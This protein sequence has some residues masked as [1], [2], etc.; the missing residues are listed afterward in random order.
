M[1][2]TTQAVCAVK[3]YILLRC[4]CLAPTLTCKYQATQKT[5]N[6]VESI[7]HLAYFVQTISEKKFYKT[8][9]KVGQK[10]KKEIKVKLPFYVPIRD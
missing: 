10:L 3:Q 7:T 2:Q 8:G 9:L 5:M 1:K 4:L 6:R